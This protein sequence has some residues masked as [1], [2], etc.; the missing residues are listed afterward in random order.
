MTATSERLHSDWTRCDAR[1]LCVE[2]LPGLL[3]RDDWAYPTP[4]TTHRRRSGAKPSR[5]RNQ[6]GPKAF[7]RYSYFTN[8]HPRST[9][10]RNPS[11]SA[12]R[13]RGDSADELGMSRA[14]T[15]CGKVMYFGIACPVCSDTDGPLVGSP[16]HD[17]SRGEH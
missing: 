9:V 17:G 10:N 7:T 12:D 8:E 4:V 11:A 14:A 6:P 3:S 15:T 16:G 5:I 2:L 1:G 13:A